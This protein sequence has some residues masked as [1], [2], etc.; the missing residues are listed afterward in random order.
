MTTF[1][2]ETNAS[3]EDQKKW[4]LRKAFLRMAD[5]LQITRREL[6][7]ILG[8]SEAS[9]SRLYD[10]KRFID[11]HSKEGELAVMLLRIYRSLDILLGGNA[12]HCQ[13]W[14]RS[15]NLHLGN[16]PIRLMQT[17]EGLHNTAAYLDAVRG[18][19]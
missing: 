8:T 1:P 18:K 17:I 7:A 16:V 2:I 6:C 12:S 10:H 19:V 4:V 14:L 9:V 15:P 13:L 5:H 3:P 11:P